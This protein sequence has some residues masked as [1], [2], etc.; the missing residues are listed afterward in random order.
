MEALSE[1][2]P[3]HLMSLR[4]D[5]ACTLTRSRPMRLFSLGLLESLGLTS[6]SI[7][8]E[9]KDT[10]HQKVAGILPEITLQVMK[11]IRNRLQQFMPNI[12]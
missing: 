1:M 3:G 7:I 8:E 6:A 2:F 4:G 12:G 9:L 11:N 5:I 10:I